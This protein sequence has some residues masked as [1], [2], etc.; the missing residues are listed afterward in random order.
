[1]SKFQLIWASVHTPDPSA[2]FLSNL[3]EFNLYK[4]TRLYQVSF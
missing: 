2:Q 1:M 4:I 3:L